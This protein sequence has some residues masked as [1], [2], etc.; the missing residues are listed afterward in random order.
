[1]DTTTPIAARHGADS[2][3]VMR[4]MQLALHG[5]FV[6]LLVVGAVRSAQGASHAVAGPVGAVLLLLWYAVGLWAARSTD[7]RVGIGWFVVLVAG[8]LALIS[9]SAE[10]SWVAFALFFLALHLLPR[11]PAL[12]TVALITVAVIAAQIA[13]GTSNTVASIIGPCMG[14]LVAVG[15]SWIYAGLR[16]ESTARQ[17][18]VDELVASQD[19]VADAQRQAGVL[20]ERSRLARDIH[21]TLAQSFSSI[22]LLSRAGLAGGADGERLHDL[23][24]Q[25]DQMASSGLRDARTVVGALAPDELE[26]APLPAALG[27]LLDRLGRQIGIRTQLVVDG[28]PRPLPTT[29]EVALLRLAQ[30]ALAN[31]QQHA[32]AGRVTLTITY[33]DDAVQ[34]DVVDDGVGFDPRTRVPATGGGFGLRA[35][36][37]RMDE[38]HGTFAV[39]SAP[40]D[41][42]AVSAGVPLHTPGGQ[43]D[44]A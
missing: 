35:M 36:R 43:E 17:H 9:L 23:L 21:D 42:T 41:G 1:M 11:V 32:R 33:Q 31:V 40:G 10:F 7:R 34:L 20:A 29:V 2:T 14:A 16:A 6:L 12:C 26:Q 39:E 3:T 19:A 25:I 18:L 44:S 8:W 22:V 24:V 30:G 15:I 38:L 13:D 37:E 5:L 28:D 4:T 27:R